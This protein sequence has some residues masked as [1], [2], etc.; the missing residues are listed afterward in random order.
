M[1][2]KAFVL[3]TSKITHYDQWLL[4]NQKKTNSISKVDEIFRAIKHLIEE[5]MESITTSNR[6]TVSVFDENVK[7]YEQ[8]FFQD[9]LEQTDLKNDIIKSFY[10][11]TF[12]ILLLMRYFHFFDV[13]DIDKTLDILIKAFVFIETI[14]VK[15]ETNTKQSFAIW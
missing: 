7:D 6:A 9:F 10:I 5:E 15:S 2:V 4:I 12:L 13:S 1:V 3:K 14:T 11:S 8:C